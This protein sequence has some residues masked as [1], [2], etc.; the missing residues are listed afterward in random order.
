M[1]KLINA[2]PA[3]LV[4]DES[5]FLTSP[6]RKIKRN[7]LPYRVARVLEDGICIPTLGPEKGLLQALLSLPEII[8][9]FAGNIR[10]SLDKWS[11]RR[12]ASCGIL[13]YTIIILIHAVTARRSL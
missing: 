4:P 6:A 12:Q 7:G 9:S 13:I 5:N 1:V 2:I 11:A 10:A 3:M 8:R